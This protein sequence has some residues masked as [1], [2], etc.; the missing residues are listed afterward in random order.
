MEDF[1]QCLTESSYSRQEELVFWDCDRNKNARIAT[2][3]NKVATFAGYDYDARGYTHERLYAMQTVFLL[4]RVALRIHVLPKARDILTTTTWENGSKGA[5]MQRVF[6]MVNQTGT[7]CVSAKSDWIM[8]N[9][10]TRKILRPH[11]FIAKNEAHCPKEI[12]CPSPQKILLPKEGLEELGTRSIV[13]SDLDGNGHL[14]SGNYG[15]IIWDYLPTDL[16][17]R[18]P[19]EFFI[20]YSREATLGDQLR[21]YGFR[22]GET[23]QMEGMGEHGICFTARCVF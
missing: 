10:L 11:S 4:S 17:N 7:L 2:L 20:N 21:L 12:D 22:D 13:W 5:H 9:P 16:Q 3:L 14:Y 8:V 19:Q 23:Y 6:E 15:D 18:I 1:K